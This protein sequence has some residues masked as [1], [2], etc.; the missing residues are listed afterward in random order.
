M[1]STSSIIFQDRY[2]ITEERELAS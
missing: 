1:F 2:S